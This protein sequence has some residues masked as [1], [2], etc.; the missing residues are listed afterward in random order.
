MGGYWTYYLVQDVGKAVDHR[1]CFLLV[2]WP[3]RSTT[4]RQYQISTE[5]EGTSL[6]KDTKKRT[7]GIAP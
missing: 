2:T 1:L 6:Q 5:R 7:M 3:L 4:E